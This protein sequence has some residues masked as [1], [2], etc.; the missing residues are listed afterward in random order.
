M[1]PEERTN[2]IHMQQQNSAQPSKQHTHTI[3]HTI[4][5]THTHTHTHKAAVSYIIAA[6]ISNREE[7]RLQ[8][9]LGKEEEKVY[10]PPH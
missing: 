3:T 4:T 1:D 2:T 10:C 6:V 5:Q 7:D 9:P 8:P